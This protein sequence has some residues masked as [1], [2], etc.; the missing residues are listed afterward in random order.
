MTE[1]DYL[2]IEEAIKKGVVDPVALQ[3]PYA[4]KRGVSVVDHDEQVHRFFESWNGEG[5]TY[6]AWRRQ[7]YLATKLG[8]DDVQRRS[9]RIQFRDVPSGMREPLLDIGAG[10][11]DIEMSAARRFLIDQGYVDGPKDNK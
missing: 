6:R 5:V 2:T 7:Q 3:R 4:P 9:M 11:T 1:E 8:L 10:A